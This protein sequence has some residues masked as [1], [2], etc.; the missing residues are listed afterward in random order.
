[1]LE[2]LLQWDTNVFLLINKQGSN[3]F[4]DAL[5]PLLRE[6]WVWFPLYL[7]LLWYFY[8]TY[9]L[10]N[11]LYIVVFAALMV[12]VGNT[13]LAD[14]AKNTFKRLRPCQEEVLKEKMVERVGCG[15]MYGYFSAHATNHFA[16]ALFFSLLL[17]KRFRWATFALLFWAAAIAYAQV[18]VGKHYPLDVI[19][20]AIVGSLLGILAYKLLLRSAKDIQT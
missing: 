9:K 10:K 3:A 13:L 1:M 5:M 14:T 12:V 18:Y 2:Q 6:K 15:G 11:T 20:G 8:K 7:L 17:K 19:T 4:F 16:L